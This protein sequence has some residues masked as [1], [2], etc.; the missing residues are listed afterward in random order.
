MSSCNIVAFAN[1]E[2][3]VGNKSVVAV[4]LALSLSLGAGSL[5]IAHS[6]EYLAGEFEK[7]RA[8]SPAVIT[9]GGKVVWLAGAGGTKDE[10]GKDISKDFEAQ[11]RNAFGSLDKSLKEAGGS[12][13]D[14]VKMTVYIT[15]VENGTP[16]VNMRKSFF[17]SGNYPAS[18]LITI[19]RLAWPGMLIEIDGVAVIGDECSAVKPCK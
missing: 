17:P 2:E 5:S 7:S 9:R 14:L 3:N 18:S 13:Q 12:L 16:F 4:W 11:V 10:N 1:M 15:D 19:S 8:Y 6:S